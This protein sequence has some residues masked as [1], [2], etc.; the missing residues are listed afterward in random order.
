MDQFGINEAFLDL[1]GAWM[2][3]TEG[4]LE[5][6]KSL[7]NA[8]Q[9]AGEVVSEHMR[10]A[11]NHTSKNGSDALMHWVTNL[12]WSSRHYHQ[13]LSQWLTDYIS[14]AP[15]LDDDAR[16]RAMFWFRQIMEMLTPAN[17]FWTNPKA[18]QRFL[19]SN[20]ESLL[21]GVH[22]WLGD[23]R[24][25]DGLLE[26]ADHNAFVV[27]KNLAVTPGQVVY[28]NQ[29][30]EIIQYA[31]QTAATWQV[32]IVLIQ[33]WIN[34]YYVFDL[35]PQ[36][37]FVK[38]LVSQGFTVFIT[39][40][41]NPTDDMRH[42]SFEDYLLQGA[43][44]AVKVARNICNSDH[45][46]AAGYCIG[47]TLLA[48]LAGWLAHEDNDRPL[49]DITLFATLLDFAEPGDLKAFINPRTLKGLDRMIN[50]DGIL[51]S[52]HM[53]LAFRM[54]NPGD[55]IWRYV[56]NNYFFGENPP[57]SD[58]LYWNSDSTN[59]PGAMCLFYLKAFYLENRMVRPDQLILAK[60]PINLKQVTQ[61]IY[62]VGALSDHICPWSA[63]FQ[64]CRLTGAKVRFVLSGDGHITGIVN[65]PSPWSKKKYWAGAASRR[66]DAARWLAGRKPETGSWWPD[67]VGW[68]QPRSGVQTAPPSLGS[69]DYPP[70]G[71]APGTY[72]H[73]P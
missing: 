13:V 43:M 39:S 40:W 29:L 69:K 66:R 50:T 49:A 22:T 54:L 7:N 19:K 11:G 12:A 62:A 17:F 10:H 73:E 1:N 31:P 3:D 15:D 60:R 5:K 67:W 27:G 53:A 16:Q 44:Q 57:R 46:H 38:Y 35:S 2:R 30:V 6:C 23:V 64:T 24:R 47:G 61:P 41:K 63:T 37:S 28:R 8:M 72:V 71:P 34:K 33:P 70:L 58:M 21:Q 48:A 51:R 20:G 52:R 45:V 25:G 9:S 59:L 68:L 32:P 56:V 42:I 65:P 55:L 36:N 4:L 14:N 18:V 26:L